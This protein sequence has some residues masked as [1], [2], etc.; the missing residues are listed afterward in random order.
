[1]TRYA[2]FATPYALFVSALYLWAYWGSFGIAIL[3]Y[4]SLADIV[5]VAA[6]PVALVI[7]ASG[8]GMAIGARMGEAAVS[9]LDRRPEIAKRLTP[10]AAR[11][12]LWLIAG[13][14]AFVALTF[15]FP[16]RIAIVGG[17][18]LMVC[19]PP[20]ERFGLFS[21]IQQ[22]LV[23]T[24]FIGLAL[25][26]PWLAYDRGYADAQRVATGRQFMYLVSPLEHVD[27]S[28]SAELRPRLLGYAG[29]RHFFFVPAR[30]EVLAVAKERSHTL[31]LR[32][33]PVEAGR[34]IGFIAAMKIGLEPLPRAASAPA[35]AP[36]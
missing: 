34:P 19:I 25:Y 26:G 15:D 9:K 12:G 20:A 7:F 33:H 4:L 22:P 17:A 30:S 32:R 5:R 10:K 3:Q 36:R 23:R 8:A 6:I 21:A 31:V 28:T 1:L 24:A 2:V 14:L 35:S 18:T 13:T 11:I 27:Q 16:N 29:D